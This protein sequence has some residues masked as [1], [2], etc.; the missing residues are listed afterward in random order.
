MFILRNAGHGHF[1]DQVD[2]AETCTRREAQLFT[3][4]LALAHLDGAL[5]DDQVARAFMAGDVPS[6]LRDRGVDAA[7]YPGYA[8]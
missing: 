1:G 5:K 2:E 3:R 7:A 4:G 6:A 8:I